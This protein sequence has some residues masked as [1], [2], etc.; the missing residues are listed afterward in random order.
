MGYLS[1]AVNEFQK[2]GGLEEAGRGD[3]HRR[4]GIWNVYACG[5]YAR[6]P[7]SHYWI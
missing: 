2:L 5:G 7:R 6:G 3:K 1:D 4:V